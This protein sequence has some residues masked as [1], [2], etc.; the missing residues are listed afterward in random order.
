MEFDGQIRDVAFDSFTSRSGESARGAE[1][2]R[3]RVTK[4]ESS[5]YLLTGSVPLYRD[6]I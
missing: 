2:E 3:G 4:A 6:S 5:S 1:V